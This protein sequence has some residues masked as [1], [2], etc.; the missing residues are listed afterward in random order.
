[1]H[2]ETPPKVKTGHDKCAE[3]YDSLS[4]Q[5][6]CYTSE[7]IFGMVFEYADIGD[8][9]L[10]LGIGTGLSSF[11]FQKADLE[12]YG[13]DNS[14]EMLNICRKKGI[15]PHLKLF[16]LNENIL[17]YGDHTFDH[18]IAV[19]L[20]HF[21]K[22]LEKFFRESHRILKEEGTFAFTVKDSKT[23]IF[24]EINKEYDI[25]VYGHSD[26]YIEELIQKYNFNSLKRLKFLT[27]RDLSKKSFSCFKAY[28]L[29]K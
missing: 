19:G 17:P 23:R 14:E 2:K 26:E 7:I 5:F 6:E 21:F 27:Y 18:V 24:S 15:S 11:H 25:A 29:M 4:R 9:L 10:D 22:D 13:L 28:V 16:D 12:I 1:M 20:F 3:S 8:K